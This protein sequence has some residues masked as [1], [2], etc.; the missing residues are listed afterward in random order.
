MGSRYYKKQ[1]DKKPT[2]KPIRHFS[3]LTGFGIV[4]IHRYLISRGAEAI[5]GPGFYVFLQ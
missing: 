5:A 1:S 2:Q 4:F 3:M